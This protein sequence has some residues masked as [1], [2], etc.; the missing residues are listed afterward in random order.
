VSAADPEG[1]PTEDPT[2]PTPPRRRGR[3]VAIEWLSV[4]AVA[5]LLALGMRTFVFQAFYVP[6]GSMIPTILPHDRILVDKLLFSASHLH[7]GDVI[8]FRR[9]ANDKVC[10]LDEADFVKRVIAVGGQRVFSKG[11]TVYVANKAISE[12]YLPKGQPLGMA[13]KPQT[14]PKGQLFVMGDDRPDSCDSRYWGDVPTS[15]VIGKVVLVW[16]RNGHPD[17][18]FL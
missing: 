5:L 18:H 4:A 9:P 15:N 10:G 11:Q 7:T 1:P 16:W 2:E 8:V 3:R 14:V 17:L 12:P 13:I 6:S